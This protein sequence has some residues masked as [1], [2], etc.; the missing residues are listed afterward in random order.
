M[1]RTRLSPWQYQSSGAGGEGTMKFVKLTH[2]TPAHVANG[3]VTYRI[4][5]PTGVTGIQINT[6]KI[7]SIENIRFTVDIMDGNTS[8]TIYESNEELKY[9]YDN[10]FIPYKNDADPAL[11]VRLSNKGGIATKFDIDIRG[12]EVK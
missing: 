8:E 5:F 2:T 1:A 10:V 6:I 7:V 4:P 12:I 11:Y 9:Q 3:T